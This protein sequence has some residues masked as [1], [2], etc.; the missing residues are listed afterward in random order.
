[1]KLCF[2]GDLDDRKLTSGKIVLFGGMVVSW[3]SKK[4]GCVAKSTMEA[5]Y[6]SCSIAVSTT[7][8][9]KRFID[10]LNIVILKEP[11]NVFYDNKSTI[12]FIKGGANSSKGKHNSY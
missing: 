9:A 5:K 8:L 7:A 2:A 11:V 12:F 1:M 10:N 4:Q 3:L 6:I